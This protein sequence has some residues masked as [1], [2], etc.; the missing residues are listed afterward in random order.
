[1]QVNGIIETALTVADPAK[2]A[3]FYRKLFSFPVL[4][5]SERLVALNVAD[6]NVLLL[7]RHEVTHEPLQTPGGVIPA[8]AAS[9]QSHLAFSI[10]RDELPAWKERLAEGGVKIESTVTWPQGA[11]SVYFRDLDR[12]LIELLTPGF[13]AFDK[14]R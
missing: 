11:V 14:D 9:G 1:M 10:G 6:R 5:E 13:W 8:H 2:S 7:F 4:L 3:E 12:H